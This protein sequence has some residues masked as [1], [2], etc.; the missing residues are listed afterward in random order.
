MLHRVREEIRQHANDETVVDEDGGVAHLARNGDVLRASLGLHLRDALARELLEPERLRDRLEPALLELVH[1][2]KRVDHP[3]HLADVRFGKTEEL[4]ELGPRGIELTH[5]DKLQEGHH[6]VR[7]VADVVAEHPDELLPRPL[8]LDE[9]VIAGAQ[10]VLQALREERAPHARGELHGLERLRDV[11]NAP[12]LEP[13]DHVVGLVLR[14]DEDHRD[15]SGLRVRLE[16]P[17]GLPAVDARHHDV[18]QDEIGVL[19]LRDRECLLAA[20]RAEHPAAERRETA[21]QQIE[22]RGFVIDREHR[23]QAVDRRRHVV[24]SG[25]HDDRRRFGEEAREHRA[26]LGRRVRLGHE[27]VAARVDRALPVLLHRERRDRDDRDPRRPRLRAERPRD[28]P[29]VDAREQ[30]IHED[31]VR[32]LRP[33]DVESALPVRRHERLVAGGADDALRDVEVVRLVFDDEHP[34]H[35]HERTATPVKPPSTSA[36]ARTRTG[37]VNRKLLPTPT[38]LSTQMRPPCNA[39]SR[40]EIASPRPVPP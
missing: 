39:M 9:L 14:R 13:R 33:R 34:R 3:Q 28:R 10:L 21:R 15:R 18:E 20:R 35:A 19:A 6:A 5:A 38:V 12:G 25:P 31:R 32:S 22:V 26:Q 11:V 27:I 7:E 23:A 30:Q 36:A 4:R 37:N 16:P 8:D 2:E 1:I 29:A 24:P 17:A 40:F